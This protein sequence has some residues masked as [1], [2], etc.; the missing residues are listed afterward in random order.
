MTSR[1]SRRPASRW[2]VLVAVAGLLVAA[3]QLW[4]WTRQRPREP[5]PEP[6]PARDAGNDG[7]T[8]RYPSPPFSAAASES[9]PQPR[10]GAVP[11]PLAQPA[12][13]GDGAFEVHVSTSDE[14]VS[15]AE[16]RLYWRGP[17]DANT[18]TIAWRRAGAAKT[19]D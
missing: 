13:E 9:A 8:M 18:D 19:D 1:L 14:P 4:V 10:G 6:I 17:I 7:W 12:K 11:P 5:L 16:V 2:R 3:S 15:G